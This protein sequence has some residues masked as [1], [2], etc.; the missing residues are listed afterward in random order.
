VLPQ[1]IW[2]LPLLVFIHL[3]D[4]SL[5]LSP[6][7][8]LASQGLGVIICPHAPWRSRT[9]HYHSSLYIRLSIFEPNSNANGHASQMLGSG[10]WWAMWGCFPGEWQR[11]CLSL[12]VWSSPWPC[13]SWWTQAHWPKVLHQQCGPEVQTQQALTV[14]RRPVFCPSLWSLGSVTRMDALLYVLK[15]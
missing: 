3:H 2:I 6:F 12:A 15:A 13:V 9:A 1:F 14:C 4:G 7:D 8:R 10:V 5:L 11:C